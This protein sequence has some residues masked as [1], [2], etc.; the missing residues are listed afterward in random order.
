MISGFVLTQNSVKS[1]F[2][3]QFNEGNT[4]QQTTNFV[5][6]ILKEFV[7]W[8]FEKVESVEWFLVYE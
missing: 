5:Y 8:F 1:Q 6:D 2:F 7:L 4:Y 3:D